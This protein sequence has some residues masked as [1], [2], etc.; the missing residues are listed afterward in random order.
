M[1]PTVQ[2]NLPPMEVPSMDRSRTSMD[3]PRSS[4]VQDVDRSGEW[5]ELPGR[6]LGKS[7]ISRKAAAI[8]SSCDPSLLSARLAGKKHLPWTQLGAFGAEFARELVLLIIDFYDLQIGMTEQDRRDCELGR[9][10][11]QA[12]E[13]RLA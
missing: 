11:R 9:T 10:V 12:L 13:R 5:N 7:G 2:R 4:A 3:Q 6:A 8:E 1:R